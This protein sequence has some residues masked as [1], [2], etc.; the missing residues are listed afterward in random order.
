MKLHL[1]RQIKFSVHELAMVYSK[2]RCRK[3]V[4]TNLKSLEKQE[5]EERMQKFFLCYNR[6][7]KRQLLLQLYTDFSAIA[8]WKKPRGVI[9]E[10]RV[11]LTH[12][13]LRCSL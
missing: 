6:P 5:E 1:L 7:T 3:L 9:C 11:P 4:S 2:E 10:F 12:T 13:S 8:Q